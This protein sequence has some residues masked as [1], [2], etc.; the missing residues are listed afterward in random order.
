MSHDSNALFLILAFKPNDGRIDQRPRRGLLRMELVRARL[1]AAEFLE[2][3]HQA[4]EPV[5]LP[6]DLR[7][8]LFIRW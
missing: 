6:V 4:L 5:R 3:V 7:I 8:S 1:H 2:I